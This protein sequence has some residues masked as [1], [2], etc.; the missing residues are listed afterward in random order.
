MFDLVKTFIFGIFFE[1]KYRYIFLFILI[2][3]IYRFILWLLVLFMYEMSPVDFVKLNNDG[4]LTFVYAKKYEETIY[5]YNFQLPTKSG[6]KNKKYDVKDIKNTKHC[7]RDFF[8]LYKK[9]VSDLLKSSEDGKYIL[10]FEKKFLKNY[11]EISYYD[12]EK[13]ERSVFKTLREQGFIFDKNEDI[14][15]CKELKIKLKNT[16]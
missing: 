8:V 4:S 2:T 13:K 7:E 14:D 1:K 15:Y 10:K 3:L 12:S 11:G 9:A 5:P 16:K 6:R